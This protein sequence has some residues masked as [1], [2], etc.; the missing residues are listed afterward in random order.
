[1]ATNK[2]SLVERMEAQMAD[3][4]KRNARGYALAETFVMLALGACACAFIL[5]LNAALPK[6]W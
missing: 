6:D 5:A 2:K 4:E 3:L 1:M